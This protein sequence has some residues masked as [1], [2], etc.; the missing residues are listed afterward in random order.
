MFVS[1]HS[2]SP[3]A[4][5]AVSVE[6]CQN[7]TYVEALMLENEH[8]VPPIMGRRTINHAANPKNDES[9][10]ERGKS[11]PLFYKSA[12]VR[13]IIRQTARCVWQTNYIVTSG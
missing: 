13:Y 5:P 12:T 2:L 8:R 7:G 1:E 4:R 6:S 11:P 3:N 9:D 10:F